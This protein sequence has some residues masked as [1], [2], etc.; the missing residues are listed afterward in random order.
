MVPMATLSK[1]LQKAVD[2]HRVVFPKEI[3]RGIGLDWLSDHIVGPKI[4]NVFK[5]TRA[6]TETDITLGEESGVVH[7]RSHTIRVADVLRPGWKRKATAR[8]GHPCDCG[9]SDARRFLLQLPTDRIV[10]TFV[11]DQ[12]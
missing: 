4:A 3:S 1:N 5:R 9:C 11:A 10:E 6:A 12:R 8:T 2:T 7:K